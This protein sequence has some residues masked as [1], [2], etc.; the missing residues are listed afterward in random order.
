MNACLTNAALSPFSLALSSH[1]THSHLVPF[2][3]T[4]AESLLA[5]STLGRGHHFFWNLFLFAS[6]KH[7]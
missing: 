3:S 7:N 4:C 6:V 1:F 5:A 2:A